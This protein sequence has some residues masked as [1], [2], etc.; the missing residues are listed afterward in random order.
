MKTILTAL[1]LMVASASLGE[2]GSNSVCSV[3]NAASI[4]GAHSN[5]VTGT[6]GG[7]IDA[8]T[9]STRTNKKKK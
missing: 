6:T 4:T 7:S 1:I 8:Y 9:G 2:S 5:I 3:T